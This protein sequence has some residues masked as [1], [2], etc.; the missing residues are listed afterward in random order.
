M[1]D[2][3]DSFVIYRSFYEALKELPKENQADIWTAICEFSLNFNEVD[4]AGIN[5][6]VF[7]LIKPQLEANLER[8]KNGMKGAEYGRLGGRPV[9]T[10]NPK[11]PLK[12]PQNNGT[13]TPNVNVNDNVIKE[14]ISTKESLLSGKEKKQTGHFQKP[15]IDEIRAYCQERKNNIDPEKFFYHYETVGWKV[16]NNSM[17]NWHAAISTWEKNQHPSNRPSNTSE[18]AE[19][20]DPDLANRNQMRA[21]EEWRKQNAS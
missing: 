16:G 17:K 18:S 7:T 12:Y 4:L 9:K 14:N 6:T 20:Y 2:Q 8:Y 13:H 11:A 21:V 19:T 10:D 15:S 3:R 5:K 1:K